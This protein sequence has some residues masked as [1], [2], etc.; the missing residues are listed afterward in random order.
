M[1]L[2]FQLYISENSVTG[3]GWSAASRKIR[4]FLPQ[5]IRQTIRGPMLLYF[6][7][8]F[9]YLTPPPPISSSAV[10]HQTAHQRWRHWFE[11]IAT[12]SCCL[13][14]GLASNKCW[15]TSD[16]TYSNL[17][18]WTHNMARA[19]G[20]LCVAGGCLYTSEAWGPFVACPRGQGSAN[21]HQ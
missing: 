14:V 17:F 2:I 4:E 13:I 7:S 8:Y 3:N 9:S 21:I 11:K 15:L 6:I 16:K 20:D 5:C 1:T 18:I 19:T 10:S 12:L